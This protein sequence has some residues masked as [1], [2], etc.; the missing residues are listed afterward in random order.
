ADM[1]GHR[2]EKDVRP[3]RFAEGQSFRFDWSLTP[4]QAAAGRLHFETLEAA[5]R[6]VTHLGWG[7]DQAVG[8]AESQ[9]IAAPAD[10][11]AVRWLPAAAGT[12]LR[13][14]EMGT[15]AELKAKRHASLGRLGPQGSRPVPPLAG[16]RAVGYR[17]ATDPAAR[18][19]AAFAL[20]RP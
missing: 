14:P 12:L 10:R 9:A 2:T 13:V 8:N 7:V 4:Q 11:T 1:S 15:L 19:D 16:Y 17:R 20:L 3:T 6:S 5:A 18:P